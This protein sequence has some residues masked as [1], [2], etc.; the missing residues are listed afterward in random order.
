VDLLVEFSRPVCL[1][2]LLNDL[3]ALEDALQELIKA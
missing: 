2:W 3:P 1:A